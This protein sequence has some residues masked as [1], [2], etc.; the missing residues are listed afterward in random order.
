MNLAQKWAQAFKN[1]S[2]ITTTQD[3]WRLVFT[4][5]AGA[6]SKAAVPPAP[7]S[8]NFSDGSEAQIT[9]DGRLFISTGLEVPETLQ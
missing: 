4:I 9:H 7:R 8:I 6:S 3:F 1:N 2:R 5:D